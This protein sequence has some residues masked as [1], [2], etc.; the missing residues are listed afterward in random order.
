M[1]NILKIICLLT[2]AGMFGV[3][4]GGNTGKI[5]GKISD[6]QTG[7][8]LIGA[9]IIVESIWVDDKEVALENT[10]GASTD[11]EGFYFIINIRPGLYSVRVSYIGYLDQ[12]MTRVQVDIDK[13]TR[14]DYQLT[15]QL[16]ETEEIVVTAYTQKTVEKDLTA[17]KQVYNVAEVQS[18]AGV[19][20]ISDILNLQADVVDDHFRG[21]RVGESSYLLGGAAIVNPLTND[22][23][24]R[25]IVTGL[26][27]VEV[28]TSGFSAEYGNAQSGVVNMVTKEGSNRWTSRAEYSTTLPYYKTWEGSAFDPKNLDFYDLL[29]DTEEWLKENPVDPGKPMWDRGYGVTK[30]LPERIVWPPNPL[31]HQDSLKIAEL[32]RLLWLLS[33]RNVGLQYNNTWDYRADFTTGGPIAKNTNFFMAVRQNLIHPIV[34]TPTP[35]LERQL[36]ANITYQPWPNDKFKISYL[37][38]YGF[39]NYLSSNWER[40]LFDRTVSVTKRI[41]QTYQYGLEWKHVFNLAS[42]MD[43]NFNILKSI[44]KDRIEILEPGQFLDDYGNNRA[45]VDYTGPSN[46]RVGRINDDRGDQNTTTYYLGSNYT[47][48]VD[49]YN[50][51]KGGIQLSYYDLNVGY[52]NNVTNAGSMTDQ[53]FNTNPMEGAL[54]IQDKMEYEGMIANIGLRY[55]FYDLNT[56]YYTD[57]FYPLAD[58]DAKSPTLIYS[59]LQPRIGIS[60]PV[61]EVS[62][63]H[64]NYGT[65]TQRPSFNQLYFNQIRNEDGNIKAISLGNPRLRPENTKSYDVGIVNKLMTGL[66]LDVSAYYKDVKDLIQ[67]AYYR[68]KSGVSY[69][70]YINRDYADIKGFH[71]SLEK[72]S[73]SLR[74]YIRYNYESATGKSSNPDNLNVA[75]VYTED[76]ES[77]DVNLSERFPEDVYLD[78]DRK[79]KAVFNLRYRTSRDFE[80][81]I[82]GFRPLANISLSTT[83]RYSTGRPYTWDEAGEGLKY[84]KRT[85]VEREMKIRMEKRFSWADTDITTYMEIF[86][87]LNEEFWHYSRTFNNDRNLVRWETDRD[88]ILTDDEFAPYVSGQEVYLL[89]NQPR[90]YRFGIIFN[91]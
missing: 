61:S 45:W 60:F 5:A 1:K 41:D 34:P 20:D 30:Y 78:Y 70:A 89:R 43:V 23:A 33:I 13:T 76:P 29:I 68:Q 25:P 80:P 39:E 63:F 67:T 72:T 79:H 19:A 14:L 69:L 47:S 48:Q 65:F 8:P 37:Y 6:A 74:G 59:R 71:I 12:V 28:Y 50:L 32:G 3:L 42:F 31:N 56:N 52:Q 58:P 26:E 15:E 55:D 27:Q 83:L 75:P 91:F 10:T 7:E 44:E 2:T 64:L 49:K 21:G 38:N 35:D 16:M 73:G 62:V 82:Y 46:H 24:F 18:I 86:N 87:V 4:I 17:T 54:F 36:M 90:H 40:W 84:N 11:L 77:E 9:N 66:Q 81:E 85:P 53:V 51:I 22:R 57:K 88:N